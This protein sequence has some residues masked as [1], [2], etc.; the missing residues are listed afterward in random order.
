MLLGI[1]LDFS[2]FEQAGDLFFVR[3]EAAVSTSKWSQKIP[4]MKIF[5]CVSAIPHLLRS[6]M[7]DFSLFS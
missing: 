2:C 3:F 4:C 1:M 5:I 7:C 6:P